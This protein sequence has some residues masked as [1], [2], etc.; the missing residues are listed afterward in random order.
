MSIKF[1][2]FVAKKTLYILKDVYLFIHNRLKPIIKQIHK[3]KITELS[4]EIFIIILL[5]LYL[6]YFIYPI[7]KQAKIKYILIV[8]YYK[9]VFINSLRGYFHFKVVLKLNE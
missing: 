7:I 8:F 6:F 3:L 9:Y 1:I 5:I 2:E 4:Y